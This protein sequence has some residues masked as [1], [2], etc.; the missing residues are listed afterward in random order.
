M[1]R[2]RWIWVTLAPMVWLVAITMTASYQK[3]FSANP[4]IGFLSQANV[5][6]A[7]ISSGAI[8]AE[9]I[10]VTQRLIFNNRLDAAVTAVLAAMI[11]VLIVEAIGEWI[12]ILSGRKAAVLHESPYVTTRWAEGGD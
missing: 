8:P 6:A 2:A 3:I 11:L 10:A 7:Q 12:A 1:G 4:R 5:L 9:K